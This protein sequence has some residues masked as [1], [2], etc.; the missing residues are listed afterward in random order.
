MGGNPIRGGGYLFRGF[1][2]LMVPGLRQFVLVP[3]LINILLFALAIYLLVTQFSLWMEQLLAWVP[4][5][6]SFIDWLIWPIFAILVLASVY[7]S[8][9]LVANFIAAPFNGFLAERVEQRLRG[10]VNFDEGWSEGHHGRWRG[11]WRKSATWCR[12]FCWCL[13]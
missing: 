3:M 1:G 6:L 10:E 8:F 2:M 7:F 5:W 4:A 12:A 9:G 13:S 11:S